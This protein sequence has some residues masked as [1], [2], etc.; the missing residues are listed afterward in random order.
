M[1]QCLKM[2]R[3][4]AVDAARADRVWTEQVYSQRDAYEMK[5]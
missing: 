2:V 5:R 3:K 1:A 4:P